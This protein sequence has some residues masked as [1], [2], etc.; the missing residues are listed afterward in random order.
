MEK[1]IT[2]DEI[3]NLIM[4]RKGDKLYREL[5]FS[6]ILKSPDL[7]DYKKY[8]INRIRDKF[9]YIS[10][11]ELNKLSS[12]QLTFVETYLNTYF[13]PKDIRKFLDVKKSESV[14]VMTERFNEY[15]AKKFVDCL[16]G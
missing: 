8:A 1:D 13:N 4:P 2:M 10:K 16:E 12:I 7:K 11:V 3:I 9:P 6:L 5:F 14:E 15:P